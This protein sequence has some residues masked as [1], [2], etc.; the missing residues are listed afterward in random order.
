MGVG[1]GDLTA[2]ARSGTMGLTELF[3]VSQFLPL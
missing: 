2:L 3:F 1:D